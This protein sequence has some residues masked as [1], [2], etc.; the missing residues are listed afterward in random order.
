MTLAHEG[1][2]SF[3][4]S[5]GHELTNSSYRADILLM[6]NRHLRRLTVRAF[7]QCSKYKSD[8]E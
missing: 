1:L 7:D 5:S 3:Q 2:P 4:R 8:T 6:V